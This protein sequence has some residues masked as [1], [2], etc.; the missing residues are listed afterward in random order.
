MNFLDNVPLATVLALITYVTGA[1]LVVIGTIHVSNTQQ[2]LEFF[3]ALG[4]ATFGA[5]KL[6]E[7]RNGAGRG[8]RR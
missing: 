3:G 4:V 2:F 6:G 5:G 1:I 7:A 8:M